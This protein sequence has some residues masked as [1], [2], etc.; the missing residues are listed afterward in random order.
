MLRAG[1][2]AHERHI[3]QQTVRSLAIMHIT[4]ILEFEFCVKEKY[5]YLQA[6]KN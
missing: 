2:A 3:F 5:D 1:M 4:V 6:D